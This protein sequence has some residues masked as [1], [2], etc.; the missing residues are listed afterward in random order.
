MTRIAIAL[1]ENLEENIQHALKFADLS[2]SAVETLRSA[3]KNQYIDVHG[4]KI[5]KQVTDRKGVPLVSTIAGAKLAFPTKWL[6]DV[7][8]VGI[9][10]T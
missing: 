3:L 4:M 8:Q 2:E 10:C 7:H 9:C 1:Q 5:M 6:E